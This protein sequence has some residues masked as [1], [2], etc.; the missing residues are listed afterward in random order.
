MNYET[1]VN[2]WV[3]SPDLLIS[4]QFPRHIL[5]NWTMLFPATFISTS[6]K[7]GVGLEKQAATFMTLSIRRI[8]EGH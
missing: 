8:A 3:S 7:I 6:E 5:K 1:N 2:K 4:C